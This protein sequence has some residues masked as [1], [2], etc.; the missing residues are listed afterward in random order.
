LK[1]QAEDHWQ[2][3]KSLPNWDEIRARMI[4]KAAEKGFTEAQVEQGLRAF[5]KAT[6][7]AAMKPIEAPTIMFGRQL[8]SAASSRHSAIAASDIAEA[9]AKFN[10]AVAAGTKKPATNV[11]AKNLAAASSIVSAIYAAFRTGRPSAV[12]TKAQRAEKQTEQMLRQLVDAAAYYA[13]HDSGVVD[14]EL[15]RREIEVASAIRATPFARTLGRASA[16]V[17]KWNADSPYF[18][19]WQRAASSKAFESR[20]A[21]PDITPISS[22]VMSP[23]TFDGQRLSIEGKVGPISIVHRANKVISSTSLTDG[24]GAPIKV[25][26]THIKIDSGGM[27]MGTYAR[28]IG[29]FSASHAD[30]ETPVLVPER[31]NLTEDS[32]ASWFDWVA[33]RLLPVLFLTPHNLLIESSWSAGRDGPG[34]PLRYRTWASNRTR[35]V[36]VD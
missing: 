16:W 7:S 18:A 3:P 21:F 19:E 30:F 28:I 10:L 1:L 4:A 5:E 14:M 23:A 20:V 29:T 6:G 12:S 22:I 11:G 13:S 35:R 15:G 34:N 26:L 17:A 24:T 9:A 2:T 8:E 32:E 36:H 33:L 25:G 27:V 31:R